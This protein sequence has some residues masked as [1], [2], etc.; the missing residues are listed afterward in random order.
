MQ[1]S[2]VEIH[3][4]VKP[5]SKNLHIMITFQLAKGSVKQRYYTQDNVG[6]AKNIIDPTSTCL[7]IRDLYEDEYTGERKEL[8]VYRLEGKNGKTK[9]PVFLDKE[10]HYQ[11]IF[12]VKNREG[13]ANQYQIVIHH[14]MSRN[15]MHEIG[16]TS[17]PV[18][19]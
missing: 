16:I 9:I 12:I 1:Q 18:D 11:I 6:L 8:K 17:V 7:M 3:D 10:K 19:F 14:D 13:S 5:E 4:V 2:M 15:I